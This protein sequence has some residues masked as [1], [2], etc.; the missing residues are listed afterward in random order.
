[1]GAVSLAAVSVLREGER[2]AVS[3]VSAACIAWRKCIS[4]RCPT[5]PPHPPFPFL[6]SSSFVSEHREQ[7]ASLRQP[8]KYAHVAV[9]IKTSILPFYL[10]VP[11]G[12]TLV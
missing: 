2:P 8:L 7:R 6:V 5:E 12:G 9:L 3:C 1:M 10:F 11:H 4:G